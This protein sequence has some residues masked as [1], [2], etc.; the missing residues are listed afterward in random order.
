[1]A[2]VFLLVGMIVEGAYTE[3]TIARTIIV[4]PLF[5]LGAWCGR[6]LFKIAPFAWFKKIT[7]AILIATGVSILAI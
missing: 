1:V 3:A 2:I 6:T 5:I 7:Y 4:V